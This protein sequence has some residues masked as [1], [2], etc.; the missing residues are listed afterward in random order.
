MWAGPGRDGA[1]GDVRILLIL[2]GGR[3][4]K[5]NHW[6]HGHAGP[7]R[8]L[9]RREWLAWLGGLAAAG[10]APS[11][12]GGAASSG[13]NDMPSPIRFVRQALPFQL[14]NDETSILHVP[15]TMAGGVAV[16]DYNRDGRP[17][18]FFANGANLATLKK[19]A[20][21]F[22]NC[23]LRNDGNGVFTNVT[24]RAGLA[25]LGYDNGVA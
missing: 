14:E 18:I 22:V 9:N 8:S 21:K 6:L 15:A 16:F 1:A 5:G 25:G 12:V 23:L 17:D 2:R 3:S 24:A 13:R 19:D 20:P 11:V 4:L 7:S 10:L